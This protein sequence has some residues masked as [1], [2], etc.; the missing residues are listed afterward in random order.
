MH[1]NHREDE[2]ENHDRGLDFDLPRLLHRRG[3]LQLLAGASLLTLAGCATAEPTSG[4]GASST[5]AASSSEGELPEE[6]AGPFPGDGS[7]GANILTDSG[8]VRSD[9]TSSFGQS[10]TKAE[11][12]PL[13]I[14]MTILDYAAD[15]APMA[16]A[17]V[18]LWHCNRDGQ[19]SM[20]SSGVENENYLRGVQET[21][22]SGQVT[23]TSIFPAA[24]RGRWPHIHF[25]IYP[26]LEKATN[27]QNKIVTSQ[28][29]L[30]AE[31]ANQVYASAGY[32]Q[33][34]ENMSRTSLE[35][36]NVFSDGYNLQIPTFTGTTGTGF[37]LEF[38]C[39]T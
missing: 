24:Y 28:M 36:D 19:Y 10:T 1:L 5:A 26:S 32:E 4:S 20:Y 7:N 33:S 16:G 11:G 39:A 6:T 15:S 14:K 30:A 38:S 3:M 23:F 2:L 29:A 25:E 35:S 27:S 18:Y 22:E 8:V 12:V 37:S 21:D 13:T 34:A 31:T 9:I 17:A